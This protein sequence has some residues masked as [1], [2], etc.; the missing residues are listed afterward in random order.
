M[1]SWIL[2]PLTF[3]WSY[4]YML[5]MQFLF[6]GVLNFSALHTGLIEKFRDLVVSL[7]KPKTLNTCYCAYRFVVSTVLI[8]ASME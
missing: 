8:V 2:S 1:Y 4:P 3:I 6:R 5:K 7:S